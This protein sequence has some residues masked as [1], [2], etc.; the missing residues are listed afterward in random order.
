[1]DPI[2][3]PLLHPVLDEYADCTEQALAEK[4]TAFYLE[5]S[6]AL[7]DFNPRFSDIDFVAVLKGETTAANFE[8]IQRIHRRI[9]QKYPWKMS[10]MYLQARDLGGCGD[11]DTPFLKYHDGK[12][13]WTNRFELGEVT[14]WILKNHGV[15]VFG[16]SAES[17]NIAVDVDRL[18][19][20]QHRNLNTYWASWTTQPGRILALLSDWGIQWTVLGV[21]RQLYTI[22]EQKITS[23]I[24]AA[25][26]ALVRLP[27]RWHPLIRQAIALRKDPKLACYPSRLKR[28]FDAFYFIRSVIQSCNGYFASRDGMFV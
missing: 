18:L 2:I 27:E 17:L 11:A 19:R 20:M 7:G 22:H 5:G 26:Y 8:T 4:A 21:S 10:G 14:W 16:P 24:K 13:G 1:M 12:L 6:I 28:A 9:E 23:K 15:R 3:P 25:E